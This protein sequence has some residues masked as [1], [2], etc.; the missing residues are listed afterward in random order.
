LH[1]EL[2]AAFEAAE[3]ARSREPMHR[4]HRVRRRTTAVVECVSGI[5]A[6]S[7]IVAETPF[8]HRVQG[9]RGICCW[10]DLLTVSTARNDGEKQQANRG[11][12]LHCVPPNVSAMRCSMV[13]VQR[14]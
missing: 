6:R 7:R 11:K 13:D 12:R 10:G 5:Q 2:D 3:V 1:A 9:A 4:L 8:P 14:R